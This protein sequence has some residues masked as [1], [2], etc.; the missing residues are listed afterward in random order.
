MRALV[1]DLKQKVSVVTQGGDQAARDKHTARGKMLPRE[2][3]AKLLDPGSPFLEIGQ[4]AAW[5]MYGGDV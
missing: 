1:E 5:G 3:V 2:R 4:L